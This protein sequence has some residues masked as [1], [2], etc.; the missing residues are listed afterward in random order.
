MQVYLPDI[1]KH[2]PNP[3]SLHIAMYRNPLARPLVAPGIPSSMFRR[4]LFLKKTFTDVLVIA[5]GSSDGSEETDN[6]KPFEIPTDIDVEFH[7]IKHTAEEKE[8]LIID[9]RKLKEK[10]KEKDIRHHR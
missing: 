6:Q 4:P 5:T 2:M 8:K 1:L 3:Q 10:L 9:S 7:V